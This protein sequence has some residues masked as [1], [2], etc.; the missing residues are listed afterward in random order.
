MSPD[1]LLTWARGPAFDWALG[2]FAFG[3]LL[4]L[5]E[6]LSL[7]KK[8]DL[9]EGRGSGVKGGL[10]TI[11]T[12]TLPR[13]SVFAREPVRIT[14]GYVFHIGFIAV[15]LLYGPHIRLFQE[16]LGFG[17]PALP[18]SVIAG[19]GMVTMLS[20]L[21]ALALRLRN[22]VTRHI[23]TVNDYVAWAVTFLPVLTGYLA[24]SHSLLPYT[25]LLA[26]HLLSVELLLIVAPFTKLTHLFSFA[27]SR[28][29][30]G[31]Q[32]GYRGT[33]S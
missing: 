26:L 13:A 27:L 29:Y 4:R 1:S 11:V 17:W 9:A 19:L 10:K 33:E 20:L 31:Y 8:P 30:Q 18:G 25:T 23:S 14:N 28:W 24:Y 22:P 16:A 5:I 15:L 3:M 32:A 2:I 12:R 21:L 7:G 6:V